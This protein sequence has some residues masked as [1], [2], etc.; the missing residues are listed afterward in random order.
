MYILLLDRS[1]SLAAL[2]VRDSPGYLL[3]SFRYPLQIIK[4]LYYMYVSKRKIIK[5]NYA[6]GS[7]TP[8]LSDAVFKGHLIR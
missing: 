1:V 4:F 3:V 8:K 7:N 2:D 6:F 5:I